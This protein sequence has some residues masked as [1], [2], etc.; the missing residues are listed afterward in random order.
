M[1]RA[2]GLGTIVISPMVRTVFGARCLGKG[3]EQD[4]EEGRFPFV[5]KAQRCVEHKARNDRGCQA[6]QVKR[7]HGHSEDDH[8]IDHWQAT[9]LGGTAQTAKDLIAARHSY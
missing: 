1:P 9:P 2:A 8:E 5:E 7:A 3:H 6:Q 4:A